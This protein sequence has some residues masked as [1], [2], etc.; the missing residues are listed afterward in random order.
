MQSSQFRRLSGLIVT[1]L[2][3]ALVLLIGSTLLRF[4]L[5]PGTELPTPISEAEA[6]AT[7]AA[8]A[9][10]A[11]ESAAIAAGM[12][13]TFTPTAPAAGGEAPAQGTT[14][15]PGQPDAQL[16]VTLQAT[17]TRR[18][19]AGEPTVETLAPSPLPPTPTRDPN[20]LPL[21]DPAAP[22]TATVQFFANPNEVQ[23]VVFA[24]DGLWA[25]TQIGALRWDVDTGAATL[26]GLAQGLG[27][28]RLNSAIN[29]PLEG[30]GLVFGSDA[31]LQIHDS[32]D[33]SWRQELGGGS[34]LRHNDVAALACDTAQGLLVV[35]YREH[36]LDIY[37]QR[38]G[39]WYYVERSE[40][41][42]PQGVS[43]LAIG[44]GGVVWVAS[45]GALASVNG[46]RIATY[47][48][49][50]GPLTG[51]EITA[52][53]ADDAGAIWVTAGDRLYRYAEATWQ[54]YSADRVSGDF[55]SGE[56]ADVQPAQGGRVWLAGAAGEICRMDSELETCSPFYGGAEGMAPG[57]LRDLA[58]GSGGT[59]GFGTAQA[60]S[61]LLARNLW[62]TLA[63]EAPFPAANRTFAVGA[64]AAGFLWTAG[65]AG[66]Q[67]LDPAHPD[68]A[69]LVDLEASGASP[70]VRTLHADLRG[71]M[72]L[73]GQWASHFDGSAWRHFTQADGLVGDEIS[74]IAE[75]AQGRIWFG[76][77]VG[78]SIWTGTTFFNL[79]GDNGLPNAEISALAADATGMWIGSA[80]GGL[81][82]FENNQLQVLTAE[83]VDL[84]SNTVTALLATADGVLYVGTDAGLAQF[85]A[86]AVT[87]INDLPGEPVAALAVSPDGSVWVGTQGAGAWVLR[88][89]AWQAVAVQGLALPSEVN[90]IAIDLYG[91]AWL[92]A[93]DG[94]VR[95][96]PNAR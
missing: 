49:G 92:G 22:P 23:D 82:R 47:G 54:V 87:A 7:A 68:Q 1:L 51:E 96:A 61:S 35:G 52:L 44:S 70:A 18:A 73:G 46:T 84:P 4:P 85:A 95:I 91:G 48:A 45:R 62:R 3:L 77:P 11:T 59:L 2:L 65:S 27:S 20:A 10:R 21:P 83:N 28:V 33:E 30:F 8:A 56:L 40:Q 31:G 39:R 5:T 32:A 89:G 6:G 75:D 14:P 64:D 69:R 60:G 41:V 76:T 93:D 78:L 63:L 34:T 86:G 26:A 81:Y 24:G 42:A 13:P 88:D 43:A 67:Q 53:A 66:V 50:A 72:W 15:A 55:P 36:G 29:C 9:A 58:V 25:A 19:A 38:Q 37:R 74:A 17:P 80:G 90:S 57:P 16:G 94:L 79:T 12:Q 71:G